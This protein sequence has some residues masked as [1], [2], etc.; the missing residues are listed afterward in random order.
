VVAGHEDDGAADM[1][2]TN[3]LDQLKAGDRFEGDIVMIKSIG[4]GS[5][6]IAS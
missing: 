5:L 4:K 1:G 6:V 2:H 3:A